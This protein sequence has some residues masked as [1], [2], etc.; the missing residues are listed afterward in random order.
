MPRPAPCPYPYPRPKL[1]V[2]FDWSL[3]VPPHS[4]CSYVHTFIQWL[5]KIHRSRSIHT[6][7]HH[8][9]GSE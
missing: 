1:D 6:P 3:L 2:S 5:V 7:H 8:G 9:D 4:P